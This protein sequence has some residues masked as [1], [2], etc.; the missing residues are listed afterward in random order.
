MYKISCT[1]ESSLAC[2]PYFSSIFP[3]SDGA[4]DLFARLVFFNICIDVGPGVE[5]LNDVTKYF[6]LVFPTSVCLTPKSCCVVELV[7]SKITEIRKN[8]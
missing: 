5:L 4:D 2:L 7:K 8:Y 3:V 1:T 6:V